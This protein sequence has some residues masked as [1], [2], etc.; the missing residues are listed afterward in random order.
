M[1]TKAFLAIGFTDFN[2]NKKMVPV[3]GRTILGVTSDGTPDN[4]LHLAKLVCDAK[5][6]L[7]I[8]VVNNDN[9]KLLLDKA[10]EISNKVNGDWAFLDDVRN[11]EW[12]S[13]SAIV[14]VNENMVDLY[15]GKLDYLAK[16]VNV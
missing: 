12:I 15:E 16:S 5:K 8:D 10:T 13:Y 1:G 9:Y 14:W 3:Y 11:T 2:N 6:A 7:K 4:L